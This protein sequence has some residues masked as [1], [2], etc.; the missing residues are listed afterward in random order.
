MHVHL[1]NLRNLR[2]CMWGGLDEAVYLNGGYSPRYRELQ[3]WRGCRAS[4]EYLW[5]GVL[6]Y[7]TSSLV[8]WML[9][10]RVRG[11]PLV[12]CPSKDQWQWDLL[13]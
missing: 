4:V 1:Y 6:I 11:S 5:V 9:Y 2:K 3:P 12:H 8:E 13:V 10:T 7:K